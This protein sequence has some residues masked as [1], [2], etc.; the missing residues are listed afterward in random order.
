MEKW[1]SKAPSAYDLTSES[2]REQDRKMDC[3]EDPYLECVLEQ[4]NSLHSFRMLNGIQPSS[5]NAEQSKNAARM[6]KQKQNNWKEW[7][8]YIQARKQNIKTLVA[9]FVK[10][11]EAERYQSLQD[12]LRTA[13][14]K[15]GRKQNGRKK[16]E[17]L[18]LRSRSS[19]LSM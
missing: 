12:K 14:E 2:E 18:S 8:Y 3:H 1:E 9:V 15:I 10:I 19:S 5:A 11:R 17:T 16:T 4:V 13:R 6:L 7:K